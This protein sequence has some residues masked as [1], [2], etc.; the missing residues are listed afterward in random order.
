[1][2]KILVLLT[3]VLL[4]AACGKKTNFT[5]TGKIDGAAGKTV[6]L[7]HLT[8]T[9]LL[10][11]D[12][13]KLNKAGEFKMKG[14]VSEPTYFLLNL[15]D[16]NFATL[17]V[18]SAENLTITGSYNRF[19]S[20]YT[21]KGSDNSSKV[22]EL[23]LKFTAAK[24]KTDSLQKLFQKHRNDALFTPERTKW[25]NEYTKQVTDYTIYLNDFVKRNPFS[26]ASV[27]ALYQKWGENNYV[28]NDFQAMKTAASALYAVY[29][30]N[31]QVKALY[32]NALTIIREQKN[33]RLNDLM[34]QSAVNSPNIKLPDV[35]GIT[36]DL[37][38]LH[39]KNVLLQFW[40]VKDRTSRI[41]NQVLV[42]LYA[43]YKNRGFEIYMVSIDDDKAAWSAA[44]AEDRLTWINVGDMK[45]STSALINYNIHS[46]PANYL[47][48]KEGKI[49]A[50]N[51][52]GP[53][54]TSML[55][56]IL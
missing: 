14:R 55:A 32:N 48:D 19:A 23:T 4:T 46:V 54:L 20:D 34:S 27:Y 28:A 8:L 13:A 10:P 45:G 50:K 6:Y 21:V 52:R 25:N 2:N 9:A 1:M 36:R 56:K 31:D 42:E 38:S 5:I 44:I 41:Q 18:D 3:I 35:S 37:W 47:L 39:G 11:V 43:K 40:S 49:I 15:S 26:M 12:S 22:R 53:E 24:S 30:K 17:L 29:P 51:L 16:G 7:N 33:A